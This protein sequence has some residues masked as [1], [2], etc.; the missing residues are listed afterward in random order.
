MFAVWWVK[1]EWCAA[2]LETEAEAAGP[3]GPCWKWKE[4]G[5]HPECNGKKSFGM[6][7]LAS[8]LKQLPW[9]L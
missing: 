6:F 7:N 3:V 2:E 1:A 5:F 8:I 9:L 4:F